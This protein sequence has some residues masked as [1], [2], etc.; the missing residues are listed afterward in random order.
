MCRFPHTER[1]HGAKHDISGPDVSYSA[2]QNLKEPF[3]APED[4]VLDITISKPEEVIPASTLT[5]EFCTSKNADASTLDLNV[6]T[7]RI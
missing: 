6:L 7:L 3:G 1:I 5:D 4:E 2:L